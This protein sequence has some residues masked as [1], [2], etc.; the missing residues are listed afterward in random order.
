M[1]TVGKHNTAMFM[2][3]R[4][5][6]KSCLLIDSELRQDIIINMNFEIQ[7]KMYKTEK[8]LKSVIKPITQREKFPGARN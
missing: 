4:I 8:C 2:N 3:E 6:L 7:K 1:L 5:K